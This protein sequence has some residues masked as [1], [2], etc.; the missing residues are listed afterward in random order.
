MRVGED[1]IDL[2][3][4]R[5]KFNAPAGRRNEPRIEVVVELLK[6]GTKAYSRESDVCFAPLFV[7]MAT[8]VLVL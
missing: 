8:K 6:V 5:L 2:G 7:V 4:R 1:R 3:V